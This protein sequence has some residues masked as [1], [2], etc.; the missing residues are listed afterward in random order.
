MAYRVI[1]YK[2]EPDRNDLI[3]GSYEEARDAVEELEMDYLPWEIPD[4]IYEVEVVEHE[5]S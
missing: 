1:A 4:H 5:T 3:F 2:R